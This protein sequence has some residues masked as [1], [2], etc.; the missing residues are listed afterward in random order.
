MYKDTVQYNHIRNKINDDLNLP[1]LPLIC[2]NIQTI[3]NNSK[4]GKNFAI[5]QFRQAI[6]TCQ[7][8]KVLLA[9]T[10]IQY[11]IKMV[12]QIF[13]NVYPRT[14]SLSTGEIQLDICQYSF[15]SQSR[16]STTNTTTTTHYQT[17]KKLYLDFHTLYDASPSRKYHI[18]KK[19]H[20]SRKYHISNKQ[21]NH[22]S[23]RI[24]TFQENIT[25]QKNISHFKKISHF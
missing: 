24:I 18:S 7:C 13:K 3:S 15:R 23:K 20:I 5:K 22:I 17:K 21:K 14:V 10:C 6:C 8:Y 11:W 25:F 12:S 19:Y 1:I 9:D 2:K 4:H 16:L